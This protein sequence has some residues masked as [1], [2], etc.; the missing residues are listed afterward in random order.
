MTEKDSR[1]AEETALPPLKSLFLPQ[2]QAVLCINPKKANN[3]KG[4]DAKPLA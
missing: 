1:V 3:P 4:L 2:E